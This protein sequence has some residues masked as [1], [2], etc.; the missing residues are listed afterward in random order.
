MT[1]RTQRTPR[2]QR[3]GPVRGLG[4]CVVL[5]LCFAS[6]VSF[7]L[8]QPPTNLAAARPGSIRGRVELTRVAAPI[9]RRP[10]VGDLGTPAGRGLPDLRRSVGYLESAPRGPVETHRGRPPREG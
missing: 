6:L 9:E 2:A 8:I 4:A 10:G 5:C 7:V 3:A 1:S